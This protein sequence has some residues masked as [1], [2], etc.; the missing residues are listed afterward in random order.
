MATTWLA[1]YRV[2]QPKYQGPSGFY[3]QAEFPKQHYRRISTIGK[4]NLQPQHKQ[5]VLAM[6]TLNQ[7]QPILLKKI[8]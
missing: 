4:L 2:P 6:E 8:E 5:Q 3:L 1:S 7:M